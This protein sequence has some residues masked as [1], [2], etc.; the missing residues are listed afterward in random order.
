MNH[1]MALTTT[2]LLIV[3]VY[4]VAITAF[5]LR[6]AARDRSL[7]NY[8]LADRGIPAW[9]IALSIV[10]AETSTLTIISIPGLAYDTNLGFLQLVFGYLLGRVV[11]CWILLPAYFRGEIFTAYEL[12]DRRFGPRLHKLT[13]STFLITRAVAE[14]V[15]VF[16]ISIVVNIALETYLLR[17]MSP[18]SATIAAIALVTAL[19]L[20]YTLEGGMRA[21]IWTDVV[22][23]F[24]YVG[25]TIIGFLTILHA[26]GGWNTVSAVATPAGKL[27]VFDF[28]P[29]FTTTYTFWSGLIGGMFLTMASHGTDQLMVQRLLAAK[30]LKQSRTA[31]LGSGAAILLQFTL[32]LL[33][34]VAL[35]AHLGGKAFGRSDRI[36][37]S[38]I[39][40]EMPHGIA[41][42]LVAAIL[43]AAM[44]NLSA[45]LNSLSSSSVVDFYLRFRPR[46]SDD[47]RIRIS[48]L[49]TLAWSLILFALA[50]ATQF[51][52]QRVLELGLSIASIPY[53]GLLGVFLLGTL[54]KRIGETPAIIGMLCGVTTNLL[55]W[56]APRIGWVDPKRAIAWTWYVVIGTLVTFGVASAASMMTG[57][58]GQRQTS[59]GA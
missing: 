43:A 48:R 1:A 42:L 25:G 33:V 53:G 31:L 59:S 19:T 36:F 49:F 50:I 34:G 41:G 8:F 17:W 39:V 5:G 38:F 4:L 26:V 44:S 20:V 27:Q 45:A 22:Q 2:D 54:T 7:R 28:A 40:S 9:A 46:A 30:N 24:I 55:L 13:A 18:T 51:G 14:G 6:F 47:Q 23:M 3:A 12:I 10:S 11:I 52:G 16:A 15:R 58:H 56:V 35:W 32:F 37:P 57:H 21:V 29:S